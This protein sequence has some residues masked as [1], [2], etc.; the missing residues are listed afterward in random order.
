MD[1][2]AASLTNFLLCKWVQSFSFS[3]LEHFSK[4]QWED[5]KPSIDANSFPV[6]HPQTYEGWSEQAC[7]AYPLSH[8]PSQGTVPSSLLTRPT[9][10]V[11]DAR[12]IPEM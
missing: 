5:Q 12:L 1:H 11:H 2:S 7:M 9:S 4:K 3:R 10:R 8:G 6:S